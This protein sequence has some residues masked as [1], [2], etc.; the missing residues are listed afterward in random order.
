MEIA[1]GGEILKYGEERSI[2]LA[3]QKPQ[4]STT[5]RAGAKLGDVLKEKLGDK[6]GGGS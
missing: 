3:Q 2:E 4:P 5:N 6:L 1:S